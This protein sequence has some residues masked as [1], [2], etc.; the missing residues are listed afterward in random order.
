MAWLGLKGWAD[1]L[2][3][4]LVRNLKWKT[5][6]EWSNLPGKVKLKVM[7]Y[8]DA[9]RAAWRAW[10]ENEELHCWSERQ[11]SQ[12]H[13]RPRPWWW[14]I[15][16][17]SSLLCP[18]WGSYRRKPGCSPGKTSLRTD[19]ETLRKWAK[20]CRWPQSRVSSAQPPP[21]GPLPIPQWAEI[22]WVRLCLLKQLN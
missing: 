1:H 4:L 15:P 8:G 17:P 19:I 16:S 14:K 12:A 2:N 20:P 11:K 9:L 6:S 3:S 13:P 18:P 10:E 5:L 22:T 21:T 7:R